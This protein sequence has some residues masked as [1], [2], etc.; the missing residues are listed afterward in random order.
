MT[1]YWND[2]SGIPEA[3]EK[4]SGIIQ[5]VSASENPIISSGL[6]VLFDGKGKLLRPG[7]FLMAAQFGKLQEKHYKLAAA[8]EMLHIATLI[9]DDVIDD[10]PLRRGFPTVHTRFGKRDAVLIGDYLLSRCFLITAEY[11]SPQNAVNLARLISI[12]CTMEI[13]QNND[14]F[15]SNLSLRSYLR[16]IMGKSALLFSLACYAG[17]YEAKAPQEVCRRLRRI[18]Y[19][20][21]IA[22]QIIDDILDYT[23]NQDLVRKP[24]GNDVTA[25]LITLPVLCALPLDNSGTLRDIFSRA[26]FTAEEGARIFNLVRQSGGAEAAGRY[27]ENYTSR[28]LREIAALPPGKNRDMLEILTRRLLIREQ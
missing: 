8:L 5:G 19:N 9:H 4:V 23:G 28:A 20:I 13:E 27:A 10:S 16:K 22:F 3:L 24:L 26:A 2:F 1:S 15:R 7:L 18:G 14:R 12:I 21:G 25:G 17:A 11:T 6:T